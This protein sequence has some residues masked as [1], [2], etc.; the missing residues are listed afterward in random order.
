MATSRK[1]RSEITSSI[2]TVWIA[3]ARIGIW[4]N[5]RSGR[6]HLFQL[7]KN[8]SRVEQRSETDNPNLIASAL[9]LVAQH[10]GFSYF[11]HGLLSLAALA[12]QRQVGF[13]FA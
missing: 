5:R 11:A 1:F 3:V 2:V 6:S 10:D 13:F 12:L 8:S 7:R 9:N 4:G